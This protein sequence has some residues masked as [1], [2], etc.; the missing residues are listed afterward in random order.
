VSTD[1]DRLGQLYDVAD[2]RETAVLDA[3][4]ERAGLI[5]VCPACR[6]V[7]VPEHR[8]CADCGAP[9]PARSPDLPIIR[10]V[11]D[12]S[13]AHL[14]QRQCQQLSGYDGV[15]AYPLA[16]DYDSYGWLLW[17]PDEVAAA[18]PDEQ[19]VEAGA[20]PAEVLAIQ[21]FARGLG[22]DFILLD[23]DAAAID[24]LPTWAW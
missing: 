2:D 4:R 16:A 15:V 23:R 19:A 6:H 12:L 1:R 10:A 13:T 14:P 7:N 24:G 17:V 21:R 8:A 5:W 22:C 3:L 11:L 20:V 9:P 18:D